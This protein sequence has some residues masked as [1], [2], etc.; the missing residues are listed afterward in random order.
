MVDGEAIR[1]GMSPLMEAVLSWHVLADAGH[2]TLQL[3]WVRRSRALPAG[4]RRDLRRMGW[5]VGGYVPA[6]FTW[7]HPS[8]EFAA[9]ITDVAAMPEELLSAE[10]RQSL[11]NA[12]IF[13]FN[14]PASEQAYWHVRIG[15]D[16][17]AVLVEFLE[18]LQEYWDVAFRAEWEEVAQRNQPMVKAVS[19][20]TRRAGAAPLLRAYRSQLDLDQQ[21]GLVLIDRPH[22]HRIVVS[23]QRPLTILLSEFAWPHLRILCDM[24]WP[25]V[26]VLP[27]QNLTR[28][29]AKPQVVQNVLDPLRALAG[30]SRL[31]MLTLLGVQPRSTNELGTLLHMSPPA[32]S[33]GLH[34]LEEAG[35][36]CSER[37]GRYVVYMPSQAG[38]RELVTQLEELIVL[39]TP[40]TPEPADAR[41][42]LAGTFRGQDS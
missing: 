23:P 25:P 40:Q 13:G 9:G 27:I 20:R 15:Q 18:I 31:S 32:V 10:L 14:R 8:K 24:S 7:S 35:L 12:P 39:L 2:H 3:P 11:K 38:L 5:V 6:V 28:G 42:P 26:L 19:E 22:D 33:R 36:V 37:E 21:R 29:H 1:V 16:P 17:R 30:E 41:A 4:L 34:R